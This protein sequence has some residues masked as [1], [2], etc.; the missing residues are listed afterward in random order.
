M[1]YSY[2]L[3]VSVPWFIE[4]REGVS[5]LRNGQTQRNDHEIPSIFTFFNTLFIMP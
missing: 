5:G 1:S 3:Q 4:Y 2:N